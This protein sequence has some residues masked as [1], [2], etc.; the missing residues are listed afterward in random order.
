MKK[1]PPDSM[2]LEA[3][4]QPAL[5]LLDELPTL[6]TLRGGLLFDEVQDKFNSL[7]AC[8]H[9]RKAQWKGWVI[10]WYVFVPT[11]TTL[12]QAL[13]WSKAFASR[14]DEGEKPWLRRG[15]HRTPG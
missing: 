3:G 6:E 5:I 8:R 12:F 9:P 4:D 15:R 14:F 10:G 13:R 1:I 2:R 7:V 11:K